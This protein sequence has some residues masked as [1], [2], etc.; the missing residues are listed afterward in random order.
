MYNF[1]VGQLVQNYP[2]PITRMEVRMNKPSLLTAERLRELLH[3]DPETGVFIWLVSTNG[4]IRVGDVAGH[5]TAAGYRRIKIDGRCYFSQRL[6]WLYVHGVFPFNQSDH[7]N[8]QRD[9]NR[10]C[11]L[12]DVDHSG[13]MQNRRRAHLQNKSGFLGVS[14]DKQR[15]KWTAIIQANGKKRNLGRFTSPEL[16]H[17]AYLKAKR[18]LHPMGTI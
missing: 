3:Y 16:A 11:N 14:L 5:L 8:G 15:G 1:G 9:D 17:A 4:R 18:E 2:A 10:L 12:R 7:R 6:A 13:N